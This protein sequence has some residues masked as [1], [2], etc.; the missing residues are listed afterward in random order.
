[1]ITRKKA[2]ILLFVVA[3]ASTAWGANNGPLSPTEA[4][5][6]FEVEPGVQLELVAA[7]P[8][9]GDPVA[10]AF[11][12]QGRMFVAENR[13]YPTESNPPAGVIA[14]L[15]D[16]DVDGRFEKRTV[17]AEGLTFPNGVLPWRGG[18]LVTCAPD[19]LWLRDTNNDGRADVRRVLLTGFVTNNTT[20][21]RVS[22]PTLGVDGWVYVT[23]GL[24]G[25]KVRAPDRPEIPV[26]D[27]K[28]DVRFRPDTLEFESADGKG[29]FGMTF[30][31]FGHRFHCMN[32]VHIQH[33]VLSSRELQRNPNLLFG[34]TVQD[35]PEAMAPEPLKGHGAAARIW[36]ISQNITTADSHA[37][38]F[39]AACGVLIYRGTA[40]PESHHGNAFACDPAGNLVHRDVLR[41]AGAT[42]A[43]R[44]ANEGREFVASRDDWFRPV[45]LSNGP[46]GSL[47]ICDMYRK[48]IEH[49]QYLPEEIRKRTDF[50]SGRGMGRI[51]R[52][53]EAGA[54]RAPKRFDLR[55]ASVTEL[56]G[57][58][59]HS[60]AWWRETAHR[61][62]I[63][64]N[65]RQTVSGVSGA[66]LMKSPVSAVHAL[67]VLGHF[68][69][70]TQAT[71]LA[72][73]Q[74]SHPFV[75]EQA[76]VLCRSAV[77]S[78]S[79]IQET[80]RSLANDP[81][82]HVRFQCALTLGNLAV[83]ERV[84]SLARIGAHAET[85]RWTRAAVLSSAAGC[86]VELLEASLKQR[87][88]PSPEFLIE[89]GR[90]AARSSKE[91][92]PG[93]WPI[94]ALLGVAEVYQERNQKLP[95]VS[96]SSAKRRASDMLR[97]AN[98]QIEARANAAMLL[99][100][101]D[102]TNL[103]EELAA[104]VEPGTVEA[105]QRAAIRSLCL[106]STGSDRLLSPDRWASYT[107]ALKELVLARFSSR[108][109]LLA[110]LL[111]SLEKEVVP[112]SAID[113]TR[114]RQWTNHRDTG[115]RER[116]EA[117]F[118]KSEG[119]DRMKVYEDNRSVLK[120]KPVPANGRAVFAQHCG[121]CH[122]LDREGAAVGPDLFGIRN[123]PKEAILLHIIVPEQE[124]QPGFAGYEIETKDGRVLTGLIGTESAASVTLRMARG[125]EEILARS[126]ITK[127]QATGLSLMP[128]EL[129]KN[130]SRQEM[131]DLLAYL[132]GEQ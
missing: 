102:E 85:D 123:Q 112:L 125:D 68:K 29:Q 91:L 110:V 82:T 92:V 122:R 1:M 103:V 77:K 38:T 108:P 66:E 33:V 97:V 50:D 8:T 101:L 124:I 70:L 117:L 115:I 24:T 126:A 98:G 39:T 84:P 5:R 107:P 95:E 83:E 128:Q 131:A 58:L 53:R 67:W 56:C 61:L 36:P 52:V 2:T 89:A 63:E 69:A 111:E 31:D 40:L 48:T 17:F 116:A 60:N 64:R 32:R 22:H 44:A 19:I 132:K 121:S 30:D 74:H 120:L 7:E 96:Q 9:V 73:L 54:R 23:S 129:E 35:V 87:P 10:M 65:D 47:Y 99:G 4:L 80:L 41:P 57:L 51:Y 106:M 55:G 119:S 88:L 113:A 21:L 79:T 14:M 104:L 86:E 6:S 26:L 46:D 27:S 49:P 127:M 81:D 75:R 16:A 3:W 59:T 13:G 72:G 118:K 42:F 62:L 78:S 71:L 100:Y 37:G 25:G 45:F 34:E 12:E 76:L 114:R 28:G 105:L 109:T 90:V 18:V 11:D 130:M 43:S 94:P 93:D 20:Q 15:E